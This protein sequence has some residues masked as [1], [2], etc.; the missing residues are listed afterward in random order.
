[1]PLIFFAINLFIFYSNYISATFIVLDFDLSSAVAWLN[2]LF[3][4]SL[5]SWIHIQ[6]VYLL[7]ICV[8]LEHLIL[9]RPLIYIS[10]SFCL[11]CISTHQQCR[12]F[13]YF[14]F[15]FI[16][17]SHFYI[18]LQVYFVYFCNHFQSTFWSKLFSITVNIITAPFSFSNFHLPLWASY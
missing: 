14:L 13:T 17:R 7:V 2:C 10:L 8:F 1:M 4:M 9:I 18:S 12:V 5:I 11:W 6:V 15:L 16:L 3:I